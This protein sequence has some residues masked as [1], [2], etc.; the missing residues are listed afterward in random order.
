MWWCLYLVLTQSMGVS[1]TAPRMSKVAILVPPYCLEDVSACMFLLAM[2][3]A[4]KNIQLFPRRGCILRK[5]GVGCQCIKS[6]RW[7]GLWGVNADLH[8][9][10][11]CQ[12]IMRSSTPATERHPEFTTRYE[13]INILNFELSIAAFLTRPKGSYFLFDFVF[14]PTEHFQ[15]ALIDTTFAVNELE[16][17]QSSHF[18][19]QLRINRCDWLLSF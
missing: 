19:R 11:S 8:W 2:N 9:V 14:F 1:N 18:T 17:N 4:H 3:S 16:L 10:R 7:I 6:I 5:H 15:G 12:K 13:G